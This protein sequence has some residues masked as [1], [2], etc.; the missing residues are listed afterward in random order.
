MYVQDS[1]A[2]E[3]AVVASSNPDVS[4]LGLP[5]LASLP[6]HIH[7]HPSFALHAHSRYFAVVCPL[8]V[9]LCPSTYCEQHTIKP[10]YEREAGLRAYRRTSFLPSLSAYRSHYICEM[11]HSP[12]LS[13]RKAMTTYT[14][15]SPHD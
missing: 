6:T 2:A 15:T 7:G 12:Q 1:T 14:T 10:A 8:S 5:H 3:C 9:R 4:I 13:C 11:H